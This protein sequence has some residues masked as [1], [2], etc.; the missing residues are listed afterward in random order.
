MTL[1]QRLASTLQG[2]RLLLW[3]LGSWGLIDLLPET[4]SPSSAP[5]FQSK[6]RLN[7]NH[8]QKPHRNSFDGDMRAG[9]RSLPETPRI[10]S[11]RRS[12][13]EYHHRR[14]SLQINKENMNASEEQLM[15]RLS[16]LKKHNKQLKLHNNNEDVENR[17]PAGQYYVRQIVKQVKESV[18]RKVGLDLTNTIRNREQS[19][20]ELV[21][22][23]FK[24]RKISTKVADDSCP[25]DKHSPKLRF[26]ESKSKDDINPDRS[27]FKIII[28]I[29][30]SK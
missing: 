27:T 19:R 11:G 26:L 2:P 16:S 30:T 7:Y 28:F 29:I 12:D 10:S 24:Y 21:T 14:L 5:H 4:N 18:S 17:S 20:E 13:V 3:S 1:F 6:S 15:S 22:H 9:T 8:I 23:Q 25:D